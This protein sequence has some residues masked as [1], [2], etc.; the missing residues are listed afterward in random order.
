MGSIRFQ[1]AF[2]EVI[3][4]EK[5]EVTI[6]FPFSKYSRQDIKNKLHS[7]AYSVTGKSRTGI[8]EAYGVF[9]EPAIEARIDGKK[10]SLYCK[11]PRTEKY[12]GFDLPGQPGWI[13][14]TVETEVDGTRFMIGEAI[15][16]LISASAKLRRIFDRDVLPLAWST[17]FVVQGSS[18]T[19]ISSD[20]NQFLVTVSTPGDWSTH[21]D[22]KNSLSRGRRSMVERLMPPKRFAQLSSMETDARDVE[23]SLRSFTSK[24]EIGNCAETHIFIWLCNK[25]KHENRKDDLEGLTVRLVTIKGTILEDM[26]EDVRTD[27]KDA[28]GAVLIQRLRTALNVRD[29]ENKTMKE[30]VWMVPCWRC[31]LLGSSLKDWAEEHRIAMVMEY[32]NVRSGWKSWKLRS[33]ADNEKRILGRKLP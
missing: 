13:L 16:A 33:M 18:K 22:E 7:F 1:D 8:I 19:T 25:L 30:S 17:V 15:T 32:N 20:V 14:R 31:C 10:P 26:L 28:S 5:L 27:L 6:P 3:C 9:V 24:T 23:T 11:V 4:L 12:T 21:E 29:S 2:Y